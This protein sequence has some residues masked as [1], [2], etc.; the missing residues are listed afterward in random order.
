MSDYLINHNDKLNNSYNSS[1]AT[2]SN[3][4]E[5]EI[6]SD[7]ISTLFDEEK[8]KQNK[9]NSREFCVFTI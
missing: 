3:T 8:E 4:K 1:S 2:Y 6:V 7:F 5:K 9:K